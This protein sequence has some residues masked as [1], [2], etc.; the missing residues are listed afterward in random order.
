MEVIDSLFISSTHFLRNGY[1]IAFSF[2]PQQ[3]GAGDSPDIYFLL[4]LHPADLWAPS[5][6]N[7]HRHYLISA[8]RASPLRINLKSGS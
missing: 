4:N 1:T 2:L 8:I 3:Q 6:A 5:L 7:T